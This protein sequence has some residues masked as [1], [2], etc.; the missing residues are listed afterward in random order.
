MNTQRAALS[1][2]QGYT[3]TMPPDS[4]QAEARAH[5][6]QV[7]ERSLQAVVDRVGDPGEQVYA[8]LF[9]L[10]PDALPL[11]VRDRT[12]QV[13]GEMLQRA[14]ET[15]L[16]LVH[17]GH[18]ARGMLHAEYVNHR[19]IGVPNGAYDVFFTA[20]VD[21]LRNIL[22]AEWSEQEEGAWQS[23]RDEIAAI[24]VVAESAFNGTTSEEA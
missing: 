16:D 13:R 14:F 3:S 20:I 11:F 7:I 8:R 4:V 24:V 19:Q 22:G 12:G 21:A 10:L 6:A 15:V 5:R 23:V 1:P 17:A 2:E 9:E 18:F